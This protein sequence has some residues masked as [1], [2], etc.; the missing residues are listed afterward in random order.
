[1]SS[2][3][4]RSRSTST[5]SPNATRPKPNSSVSELSFAPSKPASTCSEDA[6]KQSLQLSTAKP[7]SPQKTS[8][9]S[10]SSSLTQTVTFSKPS[11]C[12]TTNSWASCTSSYSNSRSST[13]P[14]SPLS[15]RRLP[16]SYVASTPSRS[17]SSSMM[18]SIAK[19]ENS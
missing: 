3:S 13:K 5:Y 18:R 4:T 15:R 8:S 7:G 16:A 12:T 19:P 11:R 9:T 1:M 14:P 2:P 17:A 10:T 6:S